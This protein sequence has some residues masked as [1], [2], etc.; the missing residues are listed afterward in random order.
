MKA[1]LIAAVVAFAVSAEAAPPITFEGDALG[2][3][4]SG[5]TCGA[6]GRGTPKWTVEADAT[7]SG[8]SRVLKQSG[9]ASFPWCVK[10][11]TAATDGWVEVRLRP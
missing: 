1:P 6:T 4:P 9:A 10:T 7:A 5:W 3:V 11:D 2:Q 8:K